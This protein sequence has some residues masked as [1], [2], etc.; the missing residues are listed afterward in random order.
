M[1]LSDLI[2]IDRAKG[3]FIKL[4]GGLFV[5]LFAH[6]LLCEIANHLTFPGALAVLAFFL[7]ASPIAYVIRERR[8]PTRPDGARR[9]AE[10][11]PLL[12]PT[13]DEE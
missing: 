13:E 11:T 9:G 12:P 4:I 8:R 7:C 6:D 10:R 5:L 1:R 2:D 3:I